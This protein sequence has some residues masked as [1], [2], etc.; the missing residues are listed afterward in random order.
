[1]RV[2]CLEDSPEDYELITRVLTK[3][4]SPMIFQRVETR[5]E[6]LDA[7]R[8][9]NPDVILSDHALP[10]FDSIEALE[11][12]KASG[13]DVPFILVTGAVSDEFA[14][15]S[16]K[17]GADD[18]VLKQNL[19]DLPSVVANALRVREEIKTK[20]KL[21]QELA[22]KNEELRKENKELDTFIYSVSHNIRSPLNSVQGLLQLCRVE[23]NLE[24]LNVYYSMMEKSLVQLD[25]NL[26]EVLEYAKNSKQQLRVEKI[27]FESMLN[28]NIEKMKFM[29]GASEIKFE[30][31]VQVGVSFYS[32]RY[33]MQNIAN[34]LI[35]NAI[36]YQD[37]SKPYRFVKID[38]KDDGNDILLEFK[39]N[40]IGINAKKL[41]NIFDMFFRATGVQQGVGLGLHIVKDAVQILDGE[42]KV[43]SEEGK[44][45]TFK[46]SLPNLAVGKI[47]P[48]EPGELK[49]S[50]AR[51]KT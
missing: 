47:A 9:F 32:D 25:Q 49:K 30:V 51:A 20:E 17:S 24:T 26:L 2:L 14:V 36:K 16:L 1:M 4:S 15:S 3:S 48:H 45:T 12:K 43:D 18:Y 35:S 46:V 10:Q 28:D 42:I 50:I 29:D 39:D 22:E 27:E 11:L 5:N 21:T 31:D 40:G 34:N 19:V 7:L 23:K 13:I 38:V 6:F 8:G 37:R 44:G 41:G 33:R